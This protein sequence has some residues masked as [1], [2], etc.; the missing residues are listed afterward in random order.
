MSRI[1][2]PFVIVKQNHKVVVERLG[3]FHRVLSEGLNFKVPFLDTVAY[4]HSMKEAIVHIENQTAITKD[5][6]KVNI[7]GIL[8]YKV[9]DAQKAAY[10]I[11][12]PINAVS[13]LA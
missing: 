3:R 1:L 9:V 13:L 8:F 7:D 10:E 11:N 12:N 5:N 6:V 2:S 4:R